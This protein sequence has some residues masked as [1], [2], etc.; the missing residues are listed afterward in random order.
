MPLF[1]PTGQHTLH[2]TP[3]RANRRLTKY[4]HVLCSEGAR[5]RAPSGARRGTTPLRAV[6]GQ[7]GVG[8]E[9]EGEGAIR[10]T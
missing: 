5:R 8:H 3:S 6:K 10:G 2:F 1:A 9:D 4:T 7:E